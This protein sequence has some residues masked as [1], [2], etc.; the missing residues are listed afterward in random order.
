MGG[1]ELVDGFTYTEP[2]YLAVM[3]NSSLHHVPTEVDYNKIVNSP[4]FDIC[5]KLNR[6]EIDEVWIYNGPW[7][8]FYKSTLVGPGAYAFNS[9]PVG[10]AHN[11]NKLLPI[12]RTSPE[13]IVDEAVHNFTHRAEATMAKVYGSWQEND[14]SHNWNK[15]A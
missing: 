8:G 6:G 2:Q 13:R 10:G 9:P 7:F 15:F 3:A 5:G 12:I 11:C 1:P 14:T 4:Q